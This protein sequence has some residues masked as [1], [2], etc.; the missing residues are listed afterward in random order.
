M[1]NIESYKVV[2]QGI[3]RVGDVAKVKLPGKSSF[4][5]RISEIQ[6]DDD[7]KPVNIQAIFWAKLNGDPHS[8]QGS[9][10]IVGPEAVTPVRQSKW[11]RHRSDW[12]AVKAARAAAEAAA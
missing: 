2:G 3:V 8:R 1:Q 6:A 11:E 7:G 10:R 9:W 12:P 5:A 4:M